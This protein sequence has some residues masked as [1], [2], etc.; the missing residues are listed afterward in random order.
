MLKGKTVQCVRDMTPDELAAEGWDI[1]PGDNP[2][3]IELNDGTKIFA[4]EDVEGNGPSVLFGV[5]A[6]GSFIITPE[7]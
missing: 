5:D 7:D 2:V 6:D 4:S 1:A 3:V